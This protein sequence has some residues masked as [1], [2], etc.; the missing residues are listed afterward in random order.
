MFEHVV[1]GIDGG[2]G[3]GDALELARKLTPEDTRLTIV[4]V[5]GEERHRAFGAIPGD[6]DRADS[7]AICRRAAQESPE[8]VVVS[9]RAESVARGLHQEAEKRQADLLV[10]GSSRHGVLGRVMVGDHTR[11]TLTG[12]ACAMAVAP[13]G[14]AARME[15]L[16]RVGVGYDG[17][18]ESK[19]A[20]RAAREIAGRTGGQVTALKVIG[21]ADVREQ[22]SGGDVEERIDA[23]QQQTSEQAELADAPEARVVYGE[24]LSELI[25]LSEESDLLVI[26]SRSYGPLGRLVHG[27]ISP[28][29]AR[30]AACPLVVL[31]RVASA[32]ADGRDRGRGRGRGVAIAR[33]RCETA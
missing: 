16:V 4:H 32:R 7:E 27:S 25:R 10:V 15:K 3:G 18:P 5:Y 21:W 2:E 8:A 30:Y 9:A 26:G 19:L 29:L 11:Q 20:L 14:Y 1:V 28:Q 31:P 23:A 6:I 33:S 12:A 13:R 17:S 22:G 24:P